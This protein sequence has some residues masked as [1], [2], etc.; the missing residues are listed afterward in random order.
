MRIEGILRLPTNY[1]DGTKSLKESHIS[2][3]GRII[4]NYEKGCW[5]LKR[6]KNREYHLR[7]LS[8]VLDFLGRDGKVHINSVS[9]DDLDSAIGFLDFSAK[10]YSWN[11]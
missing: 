3:D 2:I 11:N 8:E 1:K 9:N 6:T 5:P 10:S 7:D 4:A